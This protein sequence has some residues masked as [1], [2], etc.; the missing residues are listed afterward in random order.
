MPEFF[1]GEIVSGKAGRAERGDDDLA[2]CDRG[3]GAVGIGGVGGFLFL[4]SDAGLPK[5]FAGRF[6]ETQEI[7]AVLL[8][9]GLS[10]KDAVAPD[11]GSGISAFGQRRSPADVFVG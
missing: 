5:E 9:N 10:D 2:V 11:S 6:I 8:L 1:A 3:S 7:A 4:V